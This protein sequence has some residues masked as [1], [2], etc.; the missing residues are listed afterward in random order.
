MPREIRI[1]PGKAMKDGYCARI[2]CKWTWPQSRATSKYIIMLMLQRIPAGEHM[3]VDLAG[4]TN[5]DSRQLTGKIVISTYG[6]DKELSIIDTGFNQ[7]ATMTSP[8]QLDFFSA[9]NAIK[10][11]GIT[12]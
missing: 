9:I 6:P 10:R 8:G 12:T 5:P 11:N 1:E 3:I 4:V 2:G 7:A